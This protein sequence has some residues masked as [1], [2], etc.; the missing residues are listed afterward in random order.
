[1]SVPGYFLV[2]M[3]EKKLCSSGDGV[4]IPMSFV[5]ATPSRGMMTSV[6]IRSFM[7]AISSQ[8]TRSPASEPLRVCMGEKKLVL[9]QEKKGKKEVWFYMVNVVPLFHF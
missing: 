4:D 2:N 3:S 9:G 7:N 6:N 8:I 1:M 5:V